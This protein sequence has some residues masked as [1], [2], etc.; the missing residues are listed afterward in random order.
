MACL[1]WNYRKETIYRFNIPKFGD[2]YNKEHQKSFN[3][4]GPSLYNMLPLYL[5][6]KLV[7]SLAWKEGLDL[8]L[9]DIPDNP[10]TT[11]HSSGLSD[12]IMSKPRNS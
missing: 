1:A 12:V 5:R 11:K 10:V 6:N 7:G 2:Y 4:I 8:F 3:N 9:G